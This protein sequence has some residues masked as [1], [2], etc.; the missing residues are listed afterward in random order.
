MSSNINLSILILL[1]TACSNAPTETSNYKK[2]FSY[3][4]AAEFTKQ[5]ETI[6]EK[7][8]EIGFTKHT[9]IHYYCLGNTKYFAF[10]DWRTKERGDIVTWVV[11]DGEVKNYFKDESGEKERV[12]SI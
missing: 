4:A 12:N 11:I 10:S 3:T 6:P 1:L 5:G 2:H 9:L 8:K 7:L